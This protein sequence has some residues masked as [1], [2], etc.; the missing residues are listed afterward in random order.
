M[1]SGVSLPPRSSS[2]PDRRRSGTT[3]PRSQCCAIGCGP[4]RPRAPFKPSPSR[5]RPRRAVGTGQDQMLRDDFVTDFKA[6]GHI[7]IVG[8]SLA[9]LNAAETLRAEGFGGPL[10]IIGDEPD[11]PYD[12]PPLS[13]GVLTGWL[14]AEH[15]TLAQTVPLDA[16]WRLRRSAPWLDLPAKRE[17]LSVCPKPWL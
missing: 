8:A 10:T 13:K 11:L 1:P 3:P 2:C 15:T 5:C 17:L 9:G 12:R 6:H 14:P 7:V 16:E 4:R